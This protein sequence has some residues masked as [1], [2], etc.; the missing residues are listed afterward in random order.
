VRRRVALTSTD[1]RAVLDVALGLKQHEPVRM[2]AGAEDEHLFAFEH[3]HDLASDE[4]V[5]SRVRNGDGALAQP[6]PAEVECQQQRRPAGACVVVG[7]DDASDR[8]LEPRQ[9]L[10]GTRA[11]SSH[12]TAPPGSIRSIALG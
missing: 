7:R 8:Q 3:A 4:L 6:P 1:D 5:G 10:A 9:I 12:G 2:R 11:V